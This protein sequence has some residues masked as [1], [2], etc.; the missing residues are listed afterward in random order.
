MVLSDPVK[1]VSLIRFFDRITYIARLYILQC[2][3]EAAIY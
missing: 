1:I 2:S 3:S